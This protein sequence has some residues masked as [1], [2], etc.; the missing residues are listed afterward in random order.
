[1]MDAKSFYRQLRR[2][3]AKKS[4]ISAEKFVESAASS[5][6]MNGMAEKRSDKSACLN[7]GS[8]IF[9]LRVLI[10]RRLVRFWSINYEEQRIEEW[11]LLG[12]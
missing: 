4:P 7:S 5:C 9:T 8:N 3:R 12:C 1:M 10:F 6:I 2:R 11:C